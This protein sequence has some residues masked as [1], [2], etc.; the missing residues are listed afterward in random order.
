MNDETLL[1]RLKETKE[2]LLKNIDAKI[3]KVANRS[4]ERWKNM[5]LNT[6]TQAKAAERRRLID[7]GLDA[8]S[9]Q[10]SVNRDVVCV[11]SVEDPADKTPAV[12][13]KNNALYNAATDTEWQYVD[14]GDYREIDMR[15]TVAI[16]HASHYNP[17]RK[18]QR[19]MALE[20]LAGTIRYSEVKG[21]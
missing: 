12:A 13:P 8:K 4:F 16:T 10:R 5:P 3:A 21:G 1:K 2:E 6:L 17:I 7:L 11:V 18:Y 14:V 19:R 20:K 9:A 15:W